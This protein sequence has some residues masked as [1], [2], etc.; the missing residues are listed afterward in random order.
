MEVLDVVI[1]DAGEDTTV[2]YALIQTPK[3]N[4]VASQPC[5]KISRCDARHL[6]IS[7]HRSLGP[8]VND[9]F[10][11]PLCRRHHQ[12]CTGKETGRAQRFF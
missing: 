3:L 2:I 9:E 6:K 4:D 8:K 5:L 7:Q 12:S 1:V 10:T 11:V